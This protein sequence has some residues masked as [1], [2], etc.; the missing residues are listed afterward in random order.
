MIDVSEWYCAGD[1]D[2]SLVFLLE[3]DVGRCLIDS[4]AKSFQFRFNYAFVGQGLVYIENDEN[5]MAG[6]GDGNNLSTSSLSILGSLDDTRKV[7]HLDGGAVIHDLARYC[8]Q[9]RELV[10]RNFN[11]S[12]VRWRHC[13]TETNLQNA[14]RSICSSMYSSLL[15]ESR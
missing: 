11:Q 9:C 2:P 4:N 14:G 1:V 10:R 7:K 6:L 12:A 8:S 5:E 13:N 3:D 15:K